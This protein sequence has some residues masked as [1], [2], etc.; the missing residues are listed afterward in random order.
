ME[1]DVRTVTGQEREELKQ[2]IALYKQY[3]DLIH[4]GKAINSDHPDPSLLLRG[5]ISADSRE[6]LFTLAALATSQAAPPTW[7]LDGA[8]ITGQFL[9]QVGLPMPSLN[10]EH[11]IPNA[12]KAV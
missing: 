6:G 7:T 4:T 8:V 2:V 9:A 3:R 1:W 11:A 10:P 12:A 5:V